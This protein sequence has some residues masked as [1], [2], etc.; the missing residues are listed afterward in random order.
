MKR[1]IDRF[2][3]K[4]ALKVIDMIEIAFLIAFLPLTAYVIAKSL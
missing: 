2:V 3:S 1:T 4:V